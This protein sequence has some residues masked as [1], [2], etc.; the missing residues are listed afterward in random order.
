MSKKSKLFIVLAAGLVL[1][2]MVSVCLTG[3]GSSSSEAPAEEP[4][5]EEPAAE[6]P[7]EEPAA[8]EPA[9]EE[10]AAEAP[11]EENKEIGEDKALDI[12]IK[13]AGVKKADLTNISVHLDVDDGRTEYD[14]EFHKGTTEYDYNIDAYKGDIIEKDI[15]NDND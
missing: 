1:C 14:V 6:A 7:A 10:P 4:A 13:D 11:A 8:E 2:L 5:A 3:C 12:A 15:D 9:A